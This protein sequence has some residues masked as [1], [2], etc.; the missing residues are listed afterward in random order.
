[1]VVSRGVWDGVSCGEGVRRYGADGCVVSASW[2]KTVGKG[3]LWLNG[4]GGEVMR[5]WEG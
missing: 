4:A 1:M 2:G 3:L 5:W